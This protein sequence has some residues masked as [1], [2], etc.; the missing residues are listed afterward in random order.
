MIP[1]KKIPATLILLYAFAFAVLAVFYHGYQFNKGDQAE[2]LPQ[3]YRLFNPELYQGD[4]F[5]TL[6]DQ[7]FTVRE[8]WV[9]LVYGC[10]SLFGVEYA[11]FG[12]HFLSLTAVA[13]AWIRISGLLTSNLLSG[14]IAVP[15]MFTVFNGITIGGNN[16]TGSSFIGSIPAEALASLGVWLFL[17]KKRTASFILLGISTWFQALVGLQL[18]L[19]LCGLHLFSHVDLKRLKEAVLFFVGYLICASPMLGPVLFKQ[20]QTTATFDAQ[21][22]YRI[23]Y[24]YRNVLH[25]IP[26]LFPAADYIKMIL[27][28]AA[29]GYIGFVYKK[30]ISSQLFVLATFII[31]GCIIYWLL[32]EPLGIMAIG[33]LQWFKTTVWLNA[34]CAVL[35]GFWVI[36]VLK[37]I[38][39]LL[40]SNYL[41]Y[42]LPVFILAGLVL[43]FNSSRLPVQK[44]QNRYQVGNYKK[45]DLQIMH[46]W[47]S[48]HIP[49]T[50]IIL[51]PPDDDGFS[52]EAKR[53][54]PVNYKAVV[55]EPYFMFPWKQAMTDYYGVNFSTLGNQSALK[56]ALQHYQT[57]L[58][59]PPQHQIKY[60]LD[61]TTVC[62]F[63]NQTG[64][65]IHRQGKWKLSAVK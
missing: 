29:A 38:H 59:Y 16:L 14:L 27:L 36:Q 63:N 24:I 65:T 26:S 6:Y 7:T 49:V 44:L 43:I 10:S 20:F 39:P 50:S 58:A 40:L 61:D 60:R 35:I 55:H 15:L 9:W 25:Y 33:K 56:T 1:E 41:V 23:L 34:L 62:L 45:T 31:S 12:L 48:K 21:E 28:V 32:L 46:T 51:A 13:Y 17:A 64:T 3:V 2:H 18:C 53:P 47:I 22:Y 8:Y 5:L 42:L 37:K 11:C 57:V 52:C 4:F 30:V 19:L 54:M